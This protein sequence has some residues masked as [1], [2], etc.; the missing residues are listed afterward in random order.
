MP[1]VEKE[2]ARGMVSSFLMRG[3]EEMVNL[4]DPGIGDTFVGVFRE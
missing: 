3:V 2:A 1:L 4:F